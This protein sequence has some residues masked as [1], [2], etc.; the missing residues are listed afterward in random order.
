MENIP[1]YL[2]K[3]GTIEIRDALASISGRKVLDIATQS[4]GFI[5]TLM[6]TL[7]DFESFVGLDISNE[8]WDPKKFEKKPVTF[9]EMNAEN[10]EFDD[11]TFDMVTISHSLHHLT[12]INKVLAEMK[13]VL[14]PDGY[15]II[16]EMF[17]D[18]KQTEAQV[19]DTLTHH[20]YAEIDTLLGISHNQILTK[21]DLKEIVH[22]LDLK[23]LRILE[24]SHPVKCL[25]CDDKLICGNPKNKDIIDFTIKEIDKTLD[26]L[27]KHVKKHGL[28]EN[29]LVDELRVEGGRMKDIVNRDGSAPA[30][31]LFFIGQKE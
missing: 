23:E 30:S 9:L 1:E 10:L 6:A 14:K 26:R 2:L 8:K 24:S 15:F 17:C 4:G 21:N 5:S 27:N 12:K 13:R 19:A 16:Q 3:S 28:Q 31:H 11:N 29:P 22:N 18:G 25:Y 7:R 20:W